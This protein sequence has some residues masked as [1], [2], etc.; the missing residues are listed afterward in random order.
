MST[1]STSAIEV[2]LRQRLLTFTPLSGDTLTTTLGVM[3]GGNGADGRLF[4]RRPPDNIDASAKPVRY[5]VLALK[6][7]RRDAEQAERE[8]AEFEVMLF[9]RPDSQRAA[10]EAAAD[11]IEQAML[12]YKDNSTGLMGVWAGLRNSLPPFPSPADR[13]VV[14]IQLVFTLVLWPAYKTQYHDQ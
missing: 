14:Q 6:N 5:G 1:D 11:V 10:L 4:W 12:R 2:T 7:R 8:L 13:D 9:A 3:D